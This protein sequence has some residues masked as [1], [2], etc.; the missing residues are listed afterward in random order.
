M[1]ES[2][3]IAKSLQSKGLENSTFLLFKMANRHGL[4]ASALGTGTGKTVT[5]QM[6]AEGFA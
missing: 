1:V 2:I 5:L 4:I 6:L 3:F